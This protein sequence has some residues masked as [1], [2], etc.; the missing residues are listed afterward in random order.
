MSI[1][2]SSPSI[3]LNSDDWNILNYSMDVSLEIRK[4]AAISDVLDQTAEYCRRLKKA[5]DGQFLTLIINCHGYYEKG[6]P[7]FG[8]ALGTGIFQWNTHLFGKLAP[9]V[10][11]I[12]CVA[13]G[14]AAITNPGADDGDGNL[15]CSSIAQHA[16]ALLQVSQNKQRG[17]VAFHEKKGYIDDWEGIVLTYASD[18]SVI[19]VQRH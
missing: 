14:S 3:V 8:I 17:N 9:Y 18:G 1:W 7:G 19:E 13:C 10:D 11:K 5:S 15:M 4:T 16:R 6:K 2:I 12:I